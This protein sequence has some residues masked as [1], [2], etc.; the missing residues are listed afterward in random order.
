MGVITI[1]AVSISVLILGSIFFVFFIRFLVLSIGYRRSNLELA[2]GYLKSYKYLGNVS[3]KAMTLYG[4]C[5][6]VY[7][8]IVDGA[9]YKIE[10][11]ASLGNDTIATSVIVYYQKNRP[12]RAYIKEYT[13]PYE[14][15]VAILLFIVS[16]LC[17]ISGIGMLITL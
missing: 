17:L 8:Y 4:Y 11:G 3:R 7:T 1:L 12:T 13:K 2:K 14:L 5:E 16:S 6:F 15:G 10:S 9:S